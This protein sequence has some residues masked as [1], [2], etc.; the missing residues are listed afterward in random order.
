MYVK[1]L[2]LTDCNYIDLGY[3]ESQI[4]PDNLSILRL[5]A[6]RTPKNEALVSAAQRHT[7]PA[8]HA[9]ANVAFHKLPQDHLFVFEEGGSGAKFLADESG[10]TTII[11]QGQQRLLQF[12]SEVSDE[13]GRLG[14][15][16]LVDAR[17]TVAQDENLGFG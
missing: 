3:V 7:F 17:E 5:E 14:F 6:W 1:W 15:I 9:Q 10:A 8:F 16:L 4:M 12:F 13:P 2:I 11:D